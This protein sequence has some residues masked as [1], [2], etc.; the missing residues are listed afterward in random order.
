MAES[1]SGSP[2]RVRQL[3]EALDEKY[4]TDSVSA[5]YGNAGARATGGGGAGAAL[6]GMGLVFIIFW[7][8]LVGSGLTDGGVGRHS[9][10]FS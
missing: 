10:P 1:F 4:G 9:T 2:E 8:V 7:V 3:W 6:I 5:L